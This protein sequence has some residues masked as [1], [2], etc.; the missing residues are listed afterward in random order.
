MHLIAVTSIYEISNGFISGIG[1]PIYFKILGFAFLQIGLLYL[2]YKLHLSQTFSLI[3]CI[4]Y[5]IAV[6]L[7]IVFSFTKNAG[8]LYL[9]VAG[10]IG[11]FLLSLCQCKK[12]RCVAS[13]S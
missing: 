4:K 8:I 11:G 1:G 5:G 3:Y 6:F 7:T 13:Q 2:N 12:W 10:N 9:C